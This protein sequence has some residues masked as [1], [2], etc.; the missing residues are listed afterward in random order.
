MASVRQ[1]Q[2]V[3]DAH[4]WA[5]ELGAGVMVCLCVCEGGR[6]GGWRGPLP[7]PHYQHM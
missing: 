3:A 4:Y 5:G 2:R 6:G 7:I 1:M